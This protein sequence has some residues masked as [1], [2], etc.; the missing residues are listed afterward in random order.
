[1]FLLLLIATKG[2]AETGNRTPRFGWNAN[3]LS[4][5]LFPQYGQ[6]VNRLSEFSL[7]FLVLWSLFLISEVEVGFKPTNNGFADRCVNHFAIQPNQCCQTTACLANL[8]ASHQTLLMVGIIFKTNSLVHNWA[9][10]SQQ[11]Q[12]LWFQYQYFLWSILP[13]Y[14]D[15]R[16]HPVFRN[17][18]EQRLTS[19]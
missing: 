19:A 7:P 11:L 12:I 14:G 4:V 2:G 6:P 9:L 18:R 5:E 8:T 3:A 15:G 10:S 13:K 1:M 17:S 16:N